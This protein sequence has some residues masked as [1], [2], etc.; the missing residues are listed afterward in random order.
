MLF[1][2]LPFVSGALL[3]RLARFSKRSGRRNQPLVVLG[4]NLLVLVFAGSIA[5]AAF[6]T[7]YRFCYDT[8]DAWGLMQVTLRWYARHWKLNQDGFRDS[9]SAYH[10]LRTPGTR[11]I[12]FVGDSFTAGHGVPNVEDRFANRIRN[13]SRDEVHVL[14]DIGFDTGQELDIIRKRIA[15]RYQLDE[16]V[17][18]YILNDIGDISPEWQ[19]VGKRVSAD[20]PPGWLTQSLFLDMLYYRIKGRFDPDISNYCQSLRKEY[21]GPLWDV[22]QQRLKNLRSLVETNG[23][24]LLVVTFP[25]LQHIGARY[26]FRSVHAKLDRFWEE[27]GVPHLD[28]LELFDAHAGERL[29]VNAYDAHPNVL[30]HA[31]A[32]E[33]I[34]DF[35]EKNVRNRPAP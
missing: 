30:A 17:L 5:L 35:L 22:Q 24:H 4:A 13:S 18:V 27:Q 19:A 23:G 6:E 31:L 11:R 8:T 21:D 2:V 15:M 32:A 1:V 10:L 26:E 3:V 14:A 28:L 33:S 34:K 29:T 25:F 7:Y 20:R 9:V 16:V 12:T